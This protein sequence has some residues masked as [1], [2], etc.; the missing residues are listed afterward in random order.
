MKALFLHIA[1]HRWLVGLCVL[2]LLLIAGVSLVSADT[3]S[4]MIHSCVNASTG[5]IIIQ[6]AWKKCAIPY[7]TTL[8]WNGSGSSGSSGPSGPSGPTGLTGQQG[9]MGPTGPNGFTGDQGPTGPTGQAGS[10]GPTGPSGSKGDQGP[11]GPTGQAGSMGPTGPTGSKGDQGDSGPTGPSGQSGSVG[12]SGPS[13]SNGWEGPTGPTGQPGPT[14]PSGQAGPT[15]PTG[16]NGGSGPAGPSGP[17]GPAGSAGSNDRMTFSTCFT[18]TLSMNT[19]LINLATGESYP[20]PVTDLG[21]GVY[22]PVSGMLTTSLR[23]AP[24]LPLGDFDTI[25]F[26][27]LD[28]GVTPTISIGSGQSPCYISGSLGFC[29]MHADVVADR[30]YTIWAQSMSEQLSPTV[31]A[32]LYSVFVPDA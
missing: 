18:D 5:A 25:F 17:S 3:N 20:F 13:G 11:T 30:V 29:T 9:G 4:T 31:N 24:T 28:F 7:N 15:G 6:P 12:P 1:R 26:A 19:T 14:G 2:G 32:C 21:F 10:I 8:D 27:F 23:I 16:F 22:F